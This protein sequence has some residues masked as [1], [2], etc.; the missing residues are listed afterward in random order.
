MPLSNDLFQFFNPTE[1]VSVLSGDLPHWRQDGVPYF[2]TFRL[3]DSLPQGKIEE[4]K[5][6]REIWL[7]THPDPR[8]AADETHDCALG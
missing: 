5:Q 2:V 6:E 4:W 1:D 8:S 3:S 7:K